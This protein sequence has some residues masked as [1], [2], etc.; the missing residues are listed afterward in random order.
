MASKQRRL[1]EMLAASKNGQSC[2]LLLRQTNQYKVPHH[3]SGQLSDFVIVKKKN[4]NKRKHGIVWMM[5]VRLL[6]SPNPHAMPPGSRKT[7]WV[8]ISHVYGRPFSC[9]HGCNC[10]P[11]CWRIKDAPAT[12]P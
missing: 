9:D 8:K 5:Q 2:K 12:V 7:S 3:N 10:F 4:L 1:S 6:V 11:S